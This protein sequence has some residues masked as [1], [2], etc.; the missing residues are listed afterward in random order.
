VQHTQQHDRYRLGEVQRSRCGG[1]D[2]ARIMHIGVD[3]YAR[4]LR[5]LFSS[6]LA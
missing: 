6:A 4:A 2:R 3:V 1:Q 5:V